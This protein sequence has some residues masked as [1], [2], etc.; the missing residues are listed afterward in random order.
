[1]EA[2]K[3]TAFDGE[4]LLWAYDNGEWAVG[5]KNY[6]PANSFER[7]DTLELHKETD[8]T[9]VHI[10]GDCCLLL[11]DGDGNFH[12]AMMSPGCLYT[13]PRGVW[14]ATVTKPGVKMALVERSGTNMGNSEITKLEGSAR[15]AAEEAVRKA[16]F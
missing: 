9:F 7:L 3:G 10:A 5:I 8:E 13:V 11:R 16:G 15:A 1:L 14:H 4:G 2:L 12:G 6:K